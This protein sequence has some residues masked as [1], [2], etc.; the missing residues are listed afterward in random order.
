MADKSTNHLTLTPKKKVDY[1]ENLPNAYITFNQALL[2]DEKWTTKDLQKLAMKLS[3]NSKGTRDELI[4]RLLQWHKR[5]HS[6]ERRCAGSNFMLLEVELPPTPPKDTTGQSKA[7]GG[8]SPAFLSPLKVKPRRNADGSPISILSTGKKSAQ[9]KSINFSIFNGTK[10]IP[11][12]EKI[13]HRW[14]AEDGVESPEDW[15]E[16]DSDAELDNIAQEIAAA[17]SGST[18][19]TMSKISND[20]YTSACED[21]W[22]SSDLNLPSD[23]PYAR[24]TQ[25]RTTTTTVTRQPR[26][27]D[28]NDEDTMLRPVARSPS[29]RGTPLGAKPSALKSSTSSTPTKLTRIAGSPYRTLTKPLTSLTPSQTYESELS[30]GFAGLSM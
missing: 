2:D 5:Q 1:K 8:V 21:D 30:Q 4:D 19:A 17:G 6:S 16:E 25:S 14:L 24:N 28:E 3:L 13:H 23:S 12:R 26:F 10:I 7:S 15:L 22:L 29:A 11:P 9:K 20:G 27:D 18:V